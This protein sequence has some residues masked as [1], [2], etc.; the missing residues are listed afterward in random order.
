MRYRSLSSA[1][2]SVLCF[3]TFTVVTAQVSPPPNGDR[4]AGDAFDDAG[5]RLVAPT[6][7]GDGTDQRAKGEGLSGNDRASGSD[8]G[9]DTFAWNLF[10]EAGDENSRRKARRAEKKVAKENLFSGYPDIQVLPSP[11]YN[12]RYPRFEVVPNPAR[13]GRLLVQGLPLAKGIRVWVFDT[14]GNMVRRQILRRSGIQ[15]ADLPDG[16]YTLTFGFGGEYVYA[17]VLLE[18]AAP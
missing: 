13:N 11:N 17:Q 5:E 2:L 10:F 18:R 16:P 7:R 9:G 12:V 4:Y 15:M 3:L 1:L 8:D 6:T 14:W